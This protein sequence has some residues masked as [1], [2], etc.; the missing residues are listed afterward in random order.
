MTRAAWILA[1]WMVAAAAFAAEAFLAGFGDLPV[2]P[3]L[4]VVEDAGTVFDTPAGRIVE[5]Y[6]AGA[7]AR[8][9]VRDF[10]RRTLPQLGW[11]QSGDEEYRREAEKLT[12]HFDGDD[13]ALTVRFTLSPERTG[14][15]GG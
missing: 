4:R 12:I 8:K 15:R 1:C 6:A 5:G 11:N 3:G 9:S 10:Y 2:M 14:D 7:V 13:G